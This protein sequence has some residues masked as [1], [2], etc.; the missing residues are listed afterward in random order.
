MYDAIYFHEV[1]RVNILRSGREWYGESFN[2]NK[3]QN[4]A[5]ELSNVLAASK[6]IAITTQYM[7]QTYNTANLNIR[8]NE[9]DLAS[10]ELPTVS[11]FT[12]FPYQV[13]GGIVKNNSFL[14]TSILSGRE[15]TVQISHEALGSGRSDGYLDYLFLTVPQKLNFDDQQLI[16]RNREI[17]NSGIY[18]LKFTGLNSS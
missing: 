8:L 7:A 18:Q 6:D 11:D 13:K 5:F 15:L 3:T 14:T 17:Q 10:E 16:I 2:I 12:I 1:D 4:F 9:F